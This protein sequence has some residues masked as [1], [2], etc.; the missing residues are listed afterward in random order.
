M[1]KYSLV[2]PKNQH[3][4]HLMRKLICF[5]VIL[6][7]LKLAELKR[8]GF[9][10]NK[11]YSEMSIGIYGSVSTIVLYTIVIKKLLRVIYFNG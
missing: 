4:L 1:R 5:R 10:N 2:Y 6:P 3:F 8:K 7:L 9:F 11:V